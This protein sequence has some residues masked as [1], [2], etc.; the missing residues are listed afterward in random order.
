MPAEEEGRKSGLGCGEYFKSILANLFTKYQHED[1]SVILLPWLQDSTA[2]PIYTVDTLPN[3][4]NLDTL[5]VHIA[6]PSRFR[7][8]GPIWCSIRWSFNTSFDNFSDQGV[9]SAWFK[10]QDHGSYP[11]V[12]H[13]TDKEMELGFFAWSGD[14]LDTNRLLQEFHKSY[15]SPLPSQSV[16]QRPFM[17]GL[18][19]KNYSALEY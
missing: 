11:A 4:N 14:F 2:L 9:H 16:Y 1:P 12:L 17:L 19:P 3:P 13:E 18:K 8:G 6:N 7:W 5:K 10:T 15:V